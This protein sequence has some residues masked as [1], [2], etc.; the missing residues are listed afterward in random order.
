VAGTRYFLIAAVITANIAMT[1]AAI[2]KSRLQSHQQYTTE[3]SDDFYS[4]SRDEVSL[5]PKIKY[6]PKKKDLGSSSERVFT[7]G[8]INNIPF[9][10]PGEALEV[11]P[12][13]AITR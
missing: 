10:N 2:A 9:S 1:Y 4:S 7:G 13:L 5:G 12:G 8:Q 11:V 3:M 6:P